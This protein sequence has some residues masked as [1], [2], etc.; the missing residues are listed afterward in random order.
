MARCRQP[1]RSCL[2][3]CFVKV[4]VSSAFDCA[5]GIPQCHF[6]PARRN[7]SS[8]SRRR[9]VVLFVG[10]EDERD[11]S[12]GLLDQVG[13]RRASPLQ[14]P[15][16]SQ[17]R[18]SSISHQESRITAAGAESLFS[19]S[20]WSFSKRILFVSSPMRKDENLYSIDLTERTA[21]LPPIDCEWACHSDEE[22]LK[23]QKMKLL[24]ESELQEVVTNQQLHQTY[25]DVY[26][27]LRLLRFLRKSKERDVVSAAER[28][29]SFLN[30]REE[31]NVDDIR[32]MVESNGVASFAPPNDRLQTVANYFPMKFD[33]VIQSATAPGDGRRN[34]GGDN[35]VRPAILYIGSFDTLGMS[36]I[37]KSS[38]SSISLDDFLNYWIFLYESIHF[39]LYQQSV[40]NGEMMFLDELCDLSGL[41]VQQFSPYFV[42]KVMKPWLR[43]TQSYYPE[44]TRRIYVLNPPGIINLA[45]NLVTPLLSQGT[46]DKIRFEKEFVGTADDFCESSDY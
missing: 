34:K 9:V 36:E 23:L 44:T 19:L 22:K 31:N 15:R 24:L 14:Q 27:D 21:D 29:R 5:G 13:K 37:I 17:R 1:I 11:N 38:K 40:S 39:R 35:I 41:S 7:L 4:R 43:M 12:E 6:Y 2:L 30:W 8:P 33:Y 46:V 18:R 20:L 3:F 32:A 26:S 28:Y 16:S 45:W 10:G 25:P 42:T